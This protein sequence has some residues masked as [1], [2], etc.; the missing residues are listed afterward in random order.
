MRCRTVRSAPRRRTIA[1]SSS[2]CYGER[3]ARYYGVVFTLTDEVAKSCQESFGSHE[4]NGDVYDELPLTA[5]YM[6]GS[7]GVITYSFFHAD[8]R[9]PAEP[10]DILEAL[11]RTE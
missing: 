5:T 9:E 10:K 7:D 2:L 8:H 11:R 4:L 3:I 1:H 6:I